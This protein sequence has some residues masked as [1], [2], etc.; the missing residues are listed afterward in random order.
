MKIF[1]KLGTGLAGFGS[2]L[3][4]GAQGLGHK[5]KYLG[6]HAS[7]LA[8]I[9]GAGLG[10]V[11]V[12]TDNPELVKAGAQLGLGG[13]AIGYVSRVGDHTI[14]LSKSRGISDLAQKARQAYSDLAPRKSSLEKKRA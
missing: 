7:N 9:A 11:G 8:K 3:R 1:N 12:A 13:Q 14:N 10:A 5:L 2:K 4:S 6:G